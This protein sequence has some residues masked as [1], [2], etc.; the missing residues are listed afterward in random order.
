[1][2]LGG[3]YWAWRGRWALGA[4]LL[5]VGGCAAPRLS[6]DAH[7][8]VPYRPDTEGIQIVAAVSVP[9]PVASAVTQT[10]AQASTAATSAEPA[11]AAA[12]SGT[13]AVSPVA[14]TNRAVAEAAVSPMAATNQAVDSATGNPVGAAVAEEGSTLHR[15]SKVLISL[16]GIPD[17]E[18]FS[19]QIDDRGDVTFT[20]LG[21]IKIAG[22]TTSEAEDL[23]EQAYIERKIYNQINVIITAE[24]SEYFVQGEVRRPGKYSF[25]R[26]VTLLQTISEAGGFT[27]F[28][29]KRKIKVMR[30][31]TKEFAIYDAKAIAGG[32]DVDPT[33]RPGDVIDVPR[34][35]L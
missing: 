1:M 30:D 17:H 22:L 13:V 12:T 19:D 9:A 24:E 33:I 35:W 8:L 10:V 11:S 2:R 20:H 6:L 18:E 21:R 27:P 5:G 7:R 3:N 32:D 25:T 31:Q 28:A 26:K 4:A 29:N 23:V 16:R 14:S 15:G 34:G